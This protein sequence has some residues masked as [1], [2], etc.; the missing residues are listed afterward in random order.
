M[1]D[2]V[3][4]LEDLFS[5]NEAHFC[6]S[7]GVIVMRAQL[8]MYVSEAF[9]LKEMQ[10]KYETELYFY[11]YYPSYNLILLSHIIVFIPHL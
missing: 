3:G 7:I 8:C 9:F 6:C 4:N 2:L 11:F 5:H 1:S 10:A